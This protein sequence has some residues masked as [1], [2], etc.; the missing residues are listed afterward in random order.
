MQDLPPDYGII[1][2]LAST[3]QL[4]DLDAQPKIL[5][6][7]L[8]HPQKK[9]WVSTI[10]DLDTPWKING[11]KL[12]PSPMRKENDLNQTSRELCSMWIFRGVNPD[13]CFERW[14]PVMRISLPTWLKRQ[15][16]PSGCNKT[17]GKLRW[18]RPRPL[19]SYCWW[20][21]AVWAVRR[22][23]RDTPFTAWK[24]QYDWRVLKN[25]GT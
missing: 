6:L 4:L 23:L 14:L 10:S 3:T 1:L 24:T 13:V 12:Q 5:Q 8:W 25:Q 7:Y 11:W 17:A 22:W 9:G 18:W 16:A 19:K 2:N 21:K 15:F 20:L